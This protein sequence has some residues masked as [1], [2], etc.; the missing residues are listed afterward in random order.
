ME[1]GLT[2][3]LMHFGIVSILMALLLVL[4]A[5]EKRGAKKGKGD[6]GV[7]AGSKTYETAA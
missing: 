5:H 1:F 3:A 6:G 2:L 4:S 7:K